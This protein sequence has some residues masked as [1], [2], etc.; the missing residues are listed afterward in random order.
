MTLL[1]FLLVMPMVF[2]TDILHHMT[3]VMNMS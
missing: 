2:Y 3:M 1:K